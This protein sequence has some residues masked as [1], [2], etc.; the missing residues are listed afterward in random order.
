MQRYAGV[1]ARYDGM[2]AVVR[3]Q[4]EAWDTPYWNLPSGAVE[5]GETPADGAVR[6]LREESGL[7]AAA[8]ELELAWTT[9]T[10]VDGRA[11]SQSWN[12]M[13][14]VSEPAFAVDDPDGSVME[15]RWFPVKDAVRLLCD[16]PYPP[17]AVPA[18]DYLTHGIRGRNWG[19]T[20]AGEVW[21][22]EA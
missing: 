8:D 14:D 20:L 4:Y 2:V 7:I 10:V 6:E 12:Y 16:L 15:V 18:V 1:V 13:V 19:F 5:D 17:I 3:E 22:W 11:T 9:R 21:S